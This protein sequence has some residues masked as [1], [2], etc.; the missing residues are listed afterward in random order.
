M[1]DFGTLYLICGCINFAFYIGL[2]FYKLFTDFKAI[3]NATWWDVIIWGFGSV[4]VSFFGGFY[5]TFI[6]LFCLFC[7]GLSEFVSWF[8]N[9]HWDNIAEKLSRKAFV[10]DEEQV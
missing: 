2:F 8:F 3:K 10:K 4:F 9:N 5:V 6:A 1:D 7:W